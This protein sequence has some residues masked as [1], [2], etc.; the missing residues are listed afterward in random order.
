MGSFRRVVL[1]WALI[2]ALICLSA[3]AGGDVDDSGNDDDSRDDDLS[4]DDADDDDLA[5][6]DA[7]DDDI[8][9]DDTADDDTSDDD[10]ADDDTGDDDSLENLFVERVAGGCPGCTDPDIAVRPDGSVVVLASRGRELVAYESFGGAFQT[11]VILRDAGYE[12][13]VVTDPDGALHILWFHA[14]ERRMYY[15]TNADGTWLS[16][17]IDESPDEA[18]DYNFD[19][20]RAADGSLH[21]AYLRHDDD[22]ITSTLYYA[23]REDGTWSVERVR[24][25]AVEY[26]HSVAIA[27]NA[28]GEAAIAAVDGLEWQQQNLSVY[29]KPGLFWSR[30]IAITS[31]D[32]LRGVVGIAFDSTGLIHLASAIQGSPIYGVV[33]VYEEG[34]SWT[35]EGV[36]AGNMSIPVAMWLDA[37]DRPRIVFTTADLL[38]FAAWDG[39]TWQVETRGRPYWTSGAAP[40]PD[41]SVHIVLSNNLERL[42]HARWDG[43]TWTETV[44]D[45]AGKVMP[46]TSIA[47]DTHSAAFIFFRERDPMRPS[48]ANNRAGWWIV[49]PFDA[50]DFPYDV[51]LGESIAAD[52]DD[53]H[54]LYLDPVPYPQVL[55]YAKLDDVGWSF[56]TVTPY[57]PWL[58]WLDLA[59][60]SNG[61]PHACVNDRDAIAMFHMWRTGGAWNAESVDTLGRDR[62]ECHI[63]LDAADA[64]HMTYGFDAAPPTWF[65]SL[66]LLFYAN[67]LATDWDFMWIG[68]GWYGM[69]HDFALDSQG[70]AH[71]VMRN[72][73]G[74]GYATNASGAWRYEPLLEGDV[75]AIAA[76]VDPMGATHAAVSYY[77]YEPEY[78]RRIDYMNNSTGEWRRWEVDGDDPS[79]SPGEG[80]DIALDDSGRIHLSYT[81]HFALYHAV[82]PVP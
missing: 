51:Q 22:S 25:Y 82:F 54:V 74:V 2:S 3:C 14:H 15:S 4:D 39:A 37:N 31:W 73:L 18:V 16:E 59:V 68:A 43:V 53:I 79:P 70:Y 57:E 49:E 44:L 67:N 66:P 71:V 65:V 13:K 7:S 9:D 5:D 26:V 61:D 56:E 36:G 34:G 52:G 47:L 17:P 76:T 81:G 8:A 32:V 35:V 46:D 58:A 40:A 6:D 42:A 11:N 63:A 69:P 1:V 27:A 30:D 19:L 77:V 24:D 62:W 21:A 75:V 33:H 23:K 48:V 72:R 55:R 45:E 78:R 60:D 64:V 50:G 41:G 12:P 38:G 20:T 29:R 80:L 28:Q 10:T